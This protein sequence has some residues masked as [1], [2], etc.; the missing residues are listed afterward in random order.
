MPT[1]NITFYFTLRNRVA[2]N[3]QPAAETTAVGRP[4]LPVSC[5]PANKP[6]PPSKI[7]FPR[8]YMTITTLFYMLYVAIEWIAILTDSR[9][10]VSYFTVYLEL[11]DLFS[12]GLNWSIIFTLEEILYK[13][14]DKSDKKKAQ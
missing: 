11:C 5:H 2:P 8:L 3:Q 10:S 14:T 12:L 13:K 4:V 9:R 6:L 7:T 1:E